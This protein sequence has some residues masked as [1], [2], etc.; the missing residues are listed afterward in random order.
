MR[1]TQTPRHDVPTPLVVN[2]RGPR[3]S[4]VALA[5]GTLAG[6]AV[7]TAVLALRGPGGAHAAIPARTASAAMAAAAAPP[8]AAGSARLGASAAAAPQGT[9]IPAPPAPD[10]AAVAGVA[11]AHHHSRSHRPIVDDRPVDPHLAPRR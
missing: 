1:D 11:P 10:V 8:M 3:R 2:Y 9:K 6:V 5:A 7:A 4:H